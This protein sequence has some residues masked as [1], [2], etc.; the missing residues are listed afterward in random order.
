LEYFLQAWPEKSPQEKKISDLTVLLCTCHASLP[1]SEIKPWSDFHKLK[2]V[3]RTFHAVR[4]CLS[5]ADR[6]ESRDPTDHESLTKHNQKRSR[7]PI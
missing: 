2:P 6:A 4:T 5:T 7:K 1:V 3:D